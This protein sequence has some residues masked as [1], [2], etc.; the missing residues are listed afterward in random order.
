MEQVKYEPIR[1]EISEELE[2]HLIEAKESYMLEG[3]QEQQAEAKAIQQMGKAEEIGQ[4]L[5][6]IHR[7]KL[8][9]KLLM[10]TIFLMC[11]GVLVLWIKVTSNERIEG[12]FFRYGV[13]LVFGIVASI[14][15]YFL[16]YQKIIKNAKYFYGLATILMLFSMRFGVSVNGIKSWINIGGFSISVPVLVIPLY[17]LAFIGFLENMNPHQYFKFSFS[18][19]KE[20]KIRKDIFKII[21]LSV[22][23]LGLLLSIPATSSMIVLGIIYLV[24]ATVKLSELN[25]NKIKWITALWGIPLLMGILCSIIFIE[26]MP[27]ERL[28]TSFHPESDPAGGGWIGINQKIILNS[29]NA[30]GE[31]DDMSNSLEM[32]DEGT[33]F[34]FISI[35]AHFGWI[36]ALAMISVIVTF[37]IKLMLNAAK[38]KDMTG[39]LMIVGISSLFILQSIFNLLM[40]FN[41]GMKS[42]FNIPFI[43]Y[44][45]SNLFV[46]MLCLALVLAV[47]RKKDLIICTKKRV[48][49]S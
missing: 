24:I 28:I 3:M 4:K 30:F 17:I 46:N 41:V 31:A 29:A 14:Y 39:K 7:P 9:W 16:D 47:Y 36:P 20:I 22:I 42:N 23:S 44:G 12:M 33:N 40:N 10:N 35:L 18:Q 26:A 37:S 21:M 45:N 27:V 48:I 32:F 13:T 43:S 2:N 19:N 11:F 25:K 1:K 34:A 38:I 49:E 8:D 5:N 6:Q 15:I